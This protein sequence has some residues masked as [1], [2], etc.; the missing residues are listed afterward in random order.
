VAWPV[1]FSSGGFIRGS[2]LSSHVT[3]VI[4]PERVIDQIA[5]IG[6]DQVLHVAKGIAP[7]SGFA[8]GKE[9]RK[10]KILTLA[11]VSVVV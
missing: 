8:Y 11:E 10:K 1:V 6:K 2:L 7:H 3:D 9:E 4:C 5:H